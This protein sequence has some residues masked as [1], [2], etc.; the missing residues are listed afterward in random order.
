M[1]VGHLRWSY[2]CRA[3]IF[4][5]W[6]SHIHDY[7]LGGLQQQIFCLSSGGHKSKIKVSAALLPPGETILY[8]FQL[9]VLLA[10]LGIPGLVAAS[11]LAL[12]LSSHSLLPACLCVFSSCKDKVIKFK[13]PHP[14]S[15]MT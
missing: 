6:G 15:R 8:L 9:L 1:A 11:L 4:G 3:S 13:L 7:K 12:P 5:S 10:V 14:N 2:G